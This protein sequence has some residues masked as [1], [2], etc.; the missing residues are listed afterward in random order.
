MLKY[1]P[2]LMRYIISIISLAALTVF[3]ACTRPAVNASATPEPPVNTPSNAPSNTASAA[4]NAAPTATPIPN[5]EVPRI[6]L[7]DAKKAFDDGTAYFVDARPAQAY[8]DEH[9]KGAAN[10]AYNELDSHIKELK[11]K[12][13]IIVYCS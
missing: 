11:T 3:L 12:K 6:T 7:A 8:N 13:K 5:E 4:P 2:D 1:Q 9:I 10:I